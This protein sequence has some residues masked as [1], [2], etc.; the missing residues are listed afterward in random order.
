MLNDAGHSTCLRRRAHA[1]HTTT[2]WCEHDTGH[3][4]LAGRKERDGRHT[5][6]H[7]VRR[8]C[9]HTRRRAQTARRTTICP[10]IVRARPR[11]ALRASIRPYFVRFQP[12]CCAASFLTSSSRT[13]RS[14]GD[15]TYLHRRFGQQ[16]NPLNTRTRRLTRCRTA[17]PVLLVLNDDAGDQVSSTCVRL[18]EQSRLKICANTAH[19]QAGGHGA[20]GKPFHTYIVGRHIFGANTTQSGRSR[21]GSRRRQGESE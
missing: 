17:G 19:G 14:P 21:A 8:G 10:Y 20:R 15:D 9:G 11:A 6:E 5:E 18:R 12:L 7:G 3:T 4:L 1:C 16:P 2:V 13:L